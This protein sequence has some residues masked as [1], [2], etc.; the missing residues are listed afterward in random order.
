M[1]TITRKPRLSST[2]GLTI[3]LKT[4]LVGLLTQLNHK[5]SQQ[6]STS[7]SG[8]ASSL[9]SKRKGIEGQPSLYT[10]VRT[11]SKATGR[12]VGGS[13]REENFAPFSQSKTR[14]S[15]CLTEGLVALASRP[16][17]SLQELKGK[18][19]SL[20]ITTA[21]LNPG[22]LNDPTNQGYL[23]S[24]ILFFLAP[25]VAREPVGRRKN[26]RN[27]QNCQR[28]IYSFF[29]KERKRKYAFFKHI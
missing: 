13:V 3:R 10:Q 5:A 4:T 7:G 8:I 23:F 15:D 28:Q 16:D 14:L 25:I 22:F 19:Y 6:T 17:S 18:E 26:S 29:R 11:Y 9:V 2:F 12:L 21:N 24:L 27:R 1:S 20:A